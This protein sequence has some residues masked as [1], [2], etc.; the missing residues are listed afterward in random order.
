MGWFNGT[1]TATGENLLDRLSRENG[2]TADARHGN[3]IVHYFNGDAITPRRD[4]VIVHPPGDEL[5]IF[6]C[7]CRAKFVARSMT[8][9]TLALFLARNSESSLVKWQITIEDD[10][11]TAH[12]RYTALVGGLDAKAFKAICISLLAEVKFVEE[13][14]HGQGML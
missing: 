10:E 11:V 12:L 1:A 6:G 4:V 14:L 8:A 7:T 5:A 3:G 2:W 9:A 13:A